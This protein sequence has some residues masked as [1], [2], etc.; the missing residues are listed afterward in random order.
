[1]IAQLRVDATTNEH[2]AALRLLGVLPP[3]QGAVVT[4][5]AMFTHRDVCEQVSANGG[6]YILYAKDNQATLER[7]LRDLFAAAERG[8]LPPSSCGCGRRIRKR[9]RPATRG[10][11]GS[12][13]GR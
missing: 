9:L 8:R 2:K 10:T 4:A 12:R 5:D 6:D 13:C 7:D 11:G 1:M 3:L